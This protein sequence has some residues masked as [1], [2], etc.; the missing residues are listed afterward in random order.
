[1]A[2]IDKWSN[3]QWQALLMRFTLD[4]L[5]LL[6]DETKKANAASRAIKVL[7]KLKEYQVA[8]DIEDT[9]GVI[10]MQC[11]A[12]MVETYTSEWGENS[13]FREDILTVKGIKMGLN[14]A[15]TPSGNPVSLETLTVS[16]A[17]L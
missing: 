9:V 1:M 2:D 17:G 4:D 13:K 14:V 15:S 8:K 3:V 5:A 11:R 7:D 12:K 16:F 10:L 6:M